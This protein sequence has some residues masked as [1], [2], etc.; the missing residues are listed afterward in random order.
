M[1]SGASK[2]GGKKADDSGG[3]GRSP[4]SSSSSARTSKSAVVKRG[5]VDRKSNGGGSPETPRGSKREQ[6]RRDSS[7]KRNTAMESGDTRGSSIRAMRGTINK[8]GS[9]AD[10]EDG[11]DTR[12]SNSGK[13]GKLDR[14]SIGVVTSRTSVI[15]VHRPGSTPSGPMPRQDRHSVGTVSAVKVRARARDGGRARGRRPRTR[16]RG[17]TPA[18]RSLA[19]SRARSPKVSRSVD[20]KTFMAAQRERE[21]SRTDIVGTDPGTGG[22]GGGG[23]ATGEGRR[24]SRK[25]P[26]RH[27]LQMIHQSRQSVISLKDPNAPDVKRRMQLEEQVRRPRTP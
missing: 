26:S 5:S 17:L 18:P 19:R 13:S 2:S 14:H 20:A 6:S 15:S 12:P 22:M 21:M 27:S 23:G 25:E 11:T 1:G 4:E 7:M 10:P 9:F 3:A 16:A 8:R 24:K